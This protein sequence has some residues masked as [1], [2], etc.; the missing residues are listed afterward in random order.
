MVSGSTILGRRKTEGKA[1]CA[2]QLGVVIGCNVDAQT[3]IVAKKKLHKA[4]FQLCILFETYP[5]FHSTAVAE[6][7]AQQFVCILVLPVKTLFLGVY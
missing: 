6:H 4:K 2:V 5:L 1:H 7:E 3:S